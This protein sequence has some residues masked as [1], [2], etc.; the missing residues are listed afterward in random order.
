MSIFISSK[1][2]INIQSHQIDLGVIEQFNNDTT[3]FL[4]KN[5]TSKTVYLLSTQP[6][7]HYQILVSD[8]R[9]FCQAK[10]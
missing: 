2:Q 7:D 5:E 3:V 6:A 8:K 4:F 1:G 10:N 9:K